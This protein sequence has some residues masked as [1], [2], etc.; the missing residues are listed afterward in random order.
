MPEIGP[1]EILVVA[2]VAL[3][4]FGPEK[5]PEMGRKAGTFIASVRRMS[6]EV[7]SEF[8]GFMDDDDDADDDPFFPEDEK[9]T[10]ASRADEQEA[11]RAKDPGPATSEARTES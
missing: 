3:I 5:L 1:L 4:V 8:H 11:G 7:R 2:V 10:E 6:T 9:A